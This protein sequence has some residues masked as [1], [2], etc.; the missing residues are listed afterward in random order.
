MIRRFRR[1][2]TVTLRRVVVIAIGFQA[3][4]RREARALREKTMRRSSWL[5]SGGQLLL[6]PKSRVIPL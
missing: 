1:L 2:R 6:S 3:L 4:P 5:G